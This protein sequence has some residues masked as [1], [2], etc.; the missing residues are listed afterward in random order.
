M[1]KVLAFITA[2]TVIL[3]VLSLS[4]YAHNLSVNTTK[5]TYGN[6]SLVVSNN[7]LERATNISP[8][9]ARIIAE[10]FVDDMKSTGDSGWDNSTSVVSVTTMY[11]ENGDT[12]TAYSVELT[13]GYV[14]VSAYADAESL[15]PEWSDKAEPIY[16]VFD[17][18]DN[19]QIIY[20]GSYDYFLNTDDDSVVATDGNQV[21]R[22]NLVNAVEESRSI[23]NMPS[24]LIESCAINTGVS[25]LATGNDITDPVAHANATYGGSFKCVD[26]CNKWGNY[27]EYYTTGTGYNLGYD[28][29]CGPVAITNVALAHK[30]KYSHSISYY[31]S[32]CTNK[33]DLFKRIADCGISKGY[34]A[35]DEGVTI[36]VLDNYA[37]AAFNDLS[38]GA[39]VLGLYWATI[40]N[41]VSDLDTGNI[42]LMAL[43]NHESYGGCHIITAFAY[44]IL[45]S[46][47]TGFNKTYIKIA[48]GWYPNARYLDMATVVPDK[49]A[50][51]DKE[52]ANYGDAYITPGNEK[53]DEAM[54]I[55]YCQQNTY[56]KIG[57]WD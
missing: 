27:I 32:S 56:V 53:F 46:Q 44:T 37:L 11:N 20:L 31:N 3:G 16:E 45:Q 6:R 38:I 49:K 1:K 55:A 4:I 28:N 42:L 33:N 22:E 9:E 26:F 50:I 2:L 48:D 19:A 13:S 57:L 52:I 23:E 17:T 18:A 39:N 25:L 51:G 8:E 34:F 43:R 35:T 30:N 15:I 14:V 12:A 24:A 29:C 5:V 21:E 47:T 54:Y 10:L 40:D 36:R 7:A 41:I